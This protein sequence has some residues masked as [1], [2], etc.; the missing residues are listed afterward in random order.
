MPRFLETNGFEFDLQN[1]SE[2]SQVYLIRNILS[3]G[4][5]ILLFFFFLRKYFSI[6]IKSQ[7]Y[8]LIITELW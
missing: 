7:S 6:Y 8:S 1:F 5:F 4:S 3:I 2:Q